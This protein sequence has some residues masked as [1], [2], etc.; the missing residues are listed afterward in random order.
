M[1]RQQ[2]AAAVAASS[3]FATV[4]ATPVGDLDITT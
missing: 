4:A 3:E 2:G 1:Y